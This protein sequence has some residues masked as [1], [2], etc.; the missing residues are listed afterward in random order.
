MQQANK[1]TVYRPTS[2]VWPVSLGVSLQSHL[3]F[4]LTCEAHGML[5]LFMCFVLLCFMTSCVVFSTL[6]SLRIFCRPSVRQILQ[7]PIS[8]FQQLLH[9]T[10]VRTVSCVSHGYAKRWCPGGV[11]KPLP[12]VRFLTNLASN[13]ASNASL[14]S[15][16]AFYLLVFNGFSL[17]RCS[18]S[19]PPHF[20]FL[21]FLG[22]AA[23]TI[24]AILFYIVHL[25]MLFNSPLFDCICL[26]FSFIFL[27]PVCCHIHKRSFY[28]VCLL[29]HVMPSSVNSHFSLRR[30]SEHLFTAI[31]LSKTASHCCNASL[32]KFLQLL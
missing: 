3:G 16:K 19:T 12:S 8:Q 22:A 29:R 25:H 7:L 1:H 9:K 15:N 27:L 6:C 28:C 4:S 18:C 2:W 17:L 24:S 21:P 26:F 20:S 32:A 11:Q 10:V 23:L 30:S 5:M 13:G 14:C 31:D